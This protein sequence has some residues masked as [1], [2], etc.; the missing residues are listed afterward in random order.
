[1]SNRGKIEGKLTLMKIGF[2]VTQEINRKLQKNFYFFPAHYGPYSSSFEKSVKNLT[3][4]YLN[5]KQLTFSNG[6]HRYDYS[7]TDL[8]IRAFE[9]I[10]VRMPTIEKEKLHEIMKIVDDKDGRIT[11]LR[12]VYNNYPKYTTVSKIKN[13]VLNGS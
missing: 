1:M 4:K 6:N 12:Y 5:C 11:I 3:G 10:I 9:S 13:E 7:L 2:L 8:G